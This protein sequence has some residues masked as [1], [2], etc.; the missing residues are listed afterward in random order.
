MPA[1]VAAIERSTPAPALGEQIHDALLTQDEVTALRNR[2]P[3]AWELA[4]RLY[5]QRL[6]GFLVVQLSNRDQAAEALSDT[7][8]R[9]LRACPGLRGGPEQVPP[10]LFRIARNVARDRH[11]A[12]QRQPIAADEIDLPDLSATGPEGTAILQDEAAR[13]NGALEHLDPED[14]EVLLLRVCGRLSSNE[15]GRIVGKRPGAIRMQQHRALQVLA[16]RMDQT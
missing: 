16:A 1:P 12:R 4:Y 6:T 13:V 2:E 10:W 5:A 3:W 8:L 9:A 14:R 7:F 15:V 11:R